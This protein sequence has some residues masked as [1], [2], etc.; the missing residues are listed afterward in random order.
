MSSETL[1]KVRHVGKRY[2]L[3]KAPHHRL[4]QTIFRGRKQFYKEFWALQDISFELRRGECLGII[5]KNGAGK[6][7]L[8]QIIAG[9]L[10]PTKGSVDIDGRVTALLELGSGFNPEFTG[11]E[12]VYMNG[13]V[14]GLS[15]KQIQS[16]FTEIEDFADIGEF[17][18]QPVKNYSNGMTVR[19]AFSIYTVL[20]PEILVVDEI[21]SV[22]DAFFQAKCVNRIKK[23]LDQ[24]T[25]LLLGSHSTDMMKSLCRKALLLDKG[26][27][28]AYGDSEEIVSL[29]FAEGRKNQ[30]RAGEDKRGAAKE[31][32]PGRDKP[33]YEYE[34]CQDA[35]S[36]LN[37]MIGFETAAEFAARVR[38]IRYGNGKGK[39]CN[40][41][42]LDADGMPRTAFGFNEGI[43]IRAHIEA[44]DAIPDP[45]C[46]VIIRNEAGVDILHCATQ[47]SGYRLPPMEKGDKMIVDISFRNVLRGGHD[48]SVVYA[49]NNTRTC[50]DYDIVDLIDIAAVFHSDFNPR[51]PVWHE[52]WYPFKFSHIKP[53][54]EEARLQLIRE[55][56][57]K[58][59]DRQQIS[60]LNDGPDHD[61]KGAEFWL[62]GL[63]TDEIPLIGIETLSVAGHV[64]RK[65]ASDGKKALVSYHAGDMISFDVAGSKL[66]LAALKHPW[67][68]KIKLK[69]NNGIERVLSLYSAEERSEIFEIPLKI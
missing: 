63:K 69:T 53:L 27:A 8:L 26:K 2:E 13:T 48:F 54:S 40:L 56:I 16:R 11:R 14:L 61:S 1:L 59:P 5:G 67:S 41:E 30:C 31:V 37:P 21:L 20:D 7:T 60:I 34:W 9:T 36:L 62:L 66:Y 39:I 3:Y 43:V 12:N 42:L 18:D 68:G 44:F 6:S 58:S 17:I 65:A 15:R 51:Y 57:G 45:N 64:L 38:T 49:F 24:G 35:A 22:G 47:E 55:T 50:V 33:G 32:K 10:A 28:I 23:L 52:V 25:S 4:F 19:L 29:Y 46:C